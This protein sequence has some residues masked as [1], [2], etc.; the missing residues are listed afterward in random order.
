LV[1][2]V[3]AKGTKPFSRDEKGTAIE[4]ATP[5][6]LNLVK[7][8]L[9]WELRET[10]CTTRKEQKSK[11][12]KLW[13]TR[14]SDS[15]YLKKLVE[16]MPRELIEVINKEKTTTTYYYASEIYILCTLLVYFWLSNSF[17]H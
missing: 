10:S 12:V 11:I 9:A 15:N 14:M 2:A 1:S 7:K 5:Q 8:V 16:S 3:Y 13:G 6:N 4:L 17:L